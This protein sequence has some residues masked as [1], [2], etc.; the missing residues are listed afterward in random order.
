MALS[1]KLEEY[2]AALRIAERLLVKSTLPRDEFFEILR[3]IVAALAKLRDA[4]EDIQATSVA[5]KTQ[6]DEVESLLTTIQNGVTSNTSQ[7]TVVQGNV[8]TNTANINQNAS[9]VDDAESSIATLTTG[10]A[11]LNT[12]IATV[13]TP[14]VSS[15]SAAITAI[16]TQL[17]GYSALVAAVATADGVI[18]SHT[19]ELGL[20]R[21]N[22]GMAVGETFSTSLNSR[23]VSL[24]SSVSSVTA[25]STTNRTNIGT[26]GT[27]TLPVSLKQKDVEIQNAMTSLISDYNSRAGVINS[28]FS[29]VLANNIVAVQDAE[30]LSVVTSNNYVYFDYGTFTDYAGDLLGKTMYKGDMIEFW[31]VGT[32]S[33]TFTLLDV[34]VENTPNSTFYIPVWHR[35]VSDKS[36]SQSILYW[37]YVHNNSTPDRFIGYIRH[38]GGA[39]ADWTGAVYFRYTYNPDNPITGVST[40]SP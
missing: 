32:T 15:N 36:A 30:N 19:T 40:Y 13:T 7:L 1:S 28:N 11:T 31:A 20:H 21:T 29:N 35:R 26:T 2:S 14:A 4:M 6:S 34:G 10:L 8:A 37:S 39:S 3:T 22:I 38:E 24:T 27:E 25:I 9:D 23:T 16:Q 17:S 18:A 33:G 12:Q 5:T